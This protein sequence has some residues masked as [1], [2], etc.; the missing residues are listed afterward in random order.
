MPGS[1][2]SI[3]SLSKFVCT[4]AMFLQLLEQFRYTGEPNLITG[5]GLYS[6]FRKTYTLRR[7]NCN[8]TSV[9]LR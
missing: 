8:V 2:F 5:R 7:K 9:E 1:Y 4:Q 6:G 3:S